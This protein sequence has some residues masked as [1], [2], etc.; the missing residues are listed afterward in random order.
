MMANLATLSPKGSAEDAAYASWVEEKDDLTRRAILIELLEA[1]ASAVCYLVLRRNEPQLI[2]TAVNNVML[3]LDQFR[4]ESR[5]STWAH[6]VLLNDMYMERRREAARKEEE[7]S[8]KLI[9]GLVGGSTPGTVDLMLTIK[10]ICTPE[11]LAILQT[12]VVEGESTYE[13]SKS[14]GLPRETVRRKT[15]NLLEK[16]RHALA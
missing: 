3:A 2:K 9:D 1:H 16:L 7:L 4:G 5:F 10:Q 14:L 8:P 11:E 15:V 6:R 12:V 13:A